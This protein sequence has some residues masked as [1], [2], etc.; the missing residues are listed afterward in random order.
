MIMARL[1]LAVAVRIAALVVLPLACLAAAILERSFLVVVLFAAAVTAAGYI[2]DLGQ[3]KAA[4]ARATPRI[5]AG[6]VGGVAGGMAL[7]ILTLGILALF[8]ET[9]LI[10]RPTS[11]DWLAV[12][13]VF[14][15]TLGL[16]WSAAA[17]FGDEVR[18]ARVHLQSI[19]GRGTSPSTQPDGDIIEGEVIDRPDPPRD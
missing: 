13:C 1:K 9:D 3:R 14:L 16:R 18:S 2:V 17:L 5:L 15:L 12:G 19:M 4:G 11:S 6:F 8:R 10:D 7:F